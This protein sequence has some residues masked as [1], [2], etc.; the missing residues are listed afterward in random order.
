MYRAAFSFTKKGIIRFTSH[1]DLL[2]MFGRA[3]R[4]ADLPLKMTEGFNPHPKFSI[5]RAI[6]LG[7]ESEGEEA[8]VILREPVNEACFTVKLQ[9]QLPQGITLKEVKIKF[10]P[11]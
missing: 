8:E 3:F 1:L 5:K 4:R 11:T 9:E 7:V 10:L 6:K 2:R